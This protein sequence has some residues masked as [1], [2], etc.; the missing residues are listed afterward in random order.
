MYSHT[1]LTH[2]PPP[3]HLPYRDR[4]HRPRPQTSPCH[5]PQYRTDLRPAIRKSKL[6]EARIRNCHSLGI[7]WSMKDWN[8]ELTMRRRLADR[9]PL[10]GL[11]CSSGMS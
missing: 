11:F 10:S 2:P 3:P 1:I 8:I 6:A 9:D 7:C 4:I 5:H